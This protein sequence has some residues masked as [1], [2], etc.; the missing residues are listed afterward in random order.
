MATQNYRVR[1]WLR[2]AGRRQGQA[3]FEGLRDPEATPVSVYAVPMCWLPFPHTWA[4]HM[5]L[6]DCHG[7]GTCLSTVQASRV[8]AP[9]CPSTRGHSALFTASYIPSR[10]HHDVPS[11]RLGA[12]GVPATASREETFLQFYGPSFTWALGTHGT[13]GHQR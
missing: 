7:M 1:P 2:G 4:K 8:H 9:L 12:A 6:P 11:T 5:L 3:S 10:A 13:A